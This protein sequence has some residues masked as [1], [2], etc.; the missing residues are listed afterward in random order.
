MSEDQRQL[1]PVEEDFVVGEVQIPWH[2][3]WKN[4]TGHVVV[5]EDTRGDYRP[6]RIH[7]RLEELRLLVGRGVPVAR[8]DWI[9]SRGG[10]GRLR[11]I[12]EQWLEVS[13]PLHPADRQLSPDL[14]DYVAANV[15]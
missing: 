13:N 5:Q 12:V 11:Q 7:G 15:K 3:I 6:S 10:A 4:E 2:R 1:T 8:V 14:M 9:V